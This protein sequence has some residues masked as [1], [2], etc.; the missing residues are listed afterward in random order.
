MRLKFTR[1]SCPLCHNTI[2]D[3]TKLYH[4]FRSLWH[5]SDIHSILHHWHSHRTL[6]SFT[7]L[8]TNRDTHIQPIS[9]EM[10]KWRNYFPNQVNYNRIHVFH[11]T[12]RILILVEKKGNF[13]AFDSPLEWQTITIILFFFFFVAALVF[14]QQLSLYTFLPS[15]PTFVSS[16]IRLSLFCHF[17]SLPPNMWLVVVVF[18]ASFACFLSY[19]SAHY[20]I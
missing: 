17:R 13:S 8:S 4:N 2:S 14:F 16:F 9:S 15:L 10:W 19:F 3:I 5:L 11:R 20:I 1:T 7:Q 12:I 6:V 18:F